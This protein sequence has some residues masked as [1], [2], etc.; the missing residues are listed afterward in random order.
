VELGP[1]PEVYQL[2]LSVT[3]DELPKIEIVGRDNQPVHERTLPLKTR[4]AGIVAEIT[5]GG[6]TFPSEFKPNEE[7]RPYFL[8]L[9]AR[10]VAELGLLTVPVS[11]TG[12]I[13]MIRLWI[14][15]DAPACMSALYVA[16][17]YDK[18]TSL[19]YR[20]DSPAVIDRVT[21][22][23]TEFRRLFEPYEPGSQRFIF[24]QEI[25]ARGAVASN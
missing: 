21:D 15:S 18:V 2:D 23:D 9:A 11:S 14:E 3:D 8:K 1:D 17:N 13:A 5:K 25:F 4:S 20:H 10:P 7:D 6:F 19:R 12:G 24:R 22:A 16:A